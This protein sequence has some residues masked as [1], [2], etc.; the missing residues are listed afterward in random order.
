MGET[1]FKQ[2]HFRAQVL[3]AEYHCPTCRASFQKPQPSLAKNMLRLQP[4]T[5]P[6]RAAPA[7][8]G[9]CRA[10]MEEHVLRALSLPDLSDFYYPAHAGRG[11]E[12]ACVHTQ[13]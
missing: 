8:A 5:A 10:L 7:S 13:V 11:K 9:N 3:K 1:R 4:H 6:H 2:T 12:K